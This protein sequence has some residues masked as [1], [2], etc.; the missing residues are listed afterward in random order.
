MVRSMYSG[1]AGMKSNQ[2]RLDV[3]GNNISNAN[4]YGFK[5]SRATF[6]DMYYQQVRGASSG[7]QTR[8][9]INPSSIGYGAKLASVDLMMDSSSMTTTGYALD[10]CITGEGFFQVMD[11][12][13][14]IYYTKAGM[15]DIDPATGAVIDSNGNFVLGTNATNGKI[16]SSKPGQEKIFI[17]VNPVQ[18][19]VAQCVKEISGK[20]LTITS[21]NQVKDANISFAFS[22]G[23]DMPDGLKV[24]AITDS[25]SSVINLKLN[26]NATFANMAELQTEINNAITQAYGGPHP[27]G[28]YNFKVEPD[29]FVDG[30]G[31]AISLTGAQIVETASA[32]YEGGGITLTPPATPGNPEG[33]GLQADLSF[34]NGFKIV[35]TGLMF[36]GNGAVVASVDYVAANPDPPAVEEHW[37]VKMTVNGVDY[38][39]EISKDRADSSSGAN[40]LL[41]KRT[42]GDP[43]DTITVSY[44]NAK[45]LP[46]GGG[47][48]AATGLT[49]TFGTNATATPSQPTHNLGWGK[50]TF[51][52]T[53]GTEY[54][55]QDMNNLTG[56]SI[57]AD[58]TITG[59]SDAGLQVLGR[60]DLASFGNARGLMQAGNS[61]F[62]ETANSGKA[63]LA[64]AGE[65][66]T[67]AIKNSSLEM[68]NVDL[69]QE[70][71]DMIVTQRGFQASSRLITVSDTMLE[72]L[73]NLKR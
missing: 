58:G 32:D 35:E 59:T 68:S 22:K 1:V 69:A 11:P 64:I 38:T 43:N 47:N 41:L 49:C 31:A 5:S 29:P 70:F 50:S 57:G 23:T 66:G 73:I 60:I 52:L 4:T 45:N 34:L 6:R 21:T 9:G 62:T 20:T 28:V 44:P 19:N 56:I 54:T 51:T 25:S 18:A 61:Y 8:G 7:T 65:G 72:E 48:I 37:T 39:G 67:G 26:A 55:Q 3:I 33:G 24:Q 63:T 36:Q 16:N 30:T 42:G 10:A 17:S 12:D 14:N 46:S 40:T 13:G 71:S 2:N 15:F 53:G 27:G